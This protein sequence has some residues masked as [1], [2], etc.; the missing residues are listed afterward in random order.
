VSARQQRR[1]WLDSLAVGDE[2][3]VQD[4]FVGP[5]LAR[6]EVVGLDFVM[7]DGRNYPRR[8]ARNSDQHTTRLAEPTPARRALVRRANL[9][10]EI[11]AVLASGN[12]TDAQLESAARALGV[13]PG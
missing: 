1:A 3:V 6:V 12:V 9:V 5:S 8:D 2:V 11:G 13:L 10:R 7:V 4:W